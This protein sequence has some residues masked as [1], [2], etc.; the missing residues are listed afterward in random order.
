MG[1]VCGYCHFECPHKGDDDCPLTK[2]DDQ[3]TECWD[4]DCDRYCDCDICTSY[5]EG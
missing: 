1:K 3:L 4:V 5:Q 2:T